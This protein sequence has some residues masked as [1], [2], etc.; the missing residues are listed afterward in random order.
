MKRCVTAAAS[1]LFLLSIL[2]PGIGH[3]VPA[4][5]NYQGLL[6]DDAGPVTDSITMVFRLFDIQTGATPLW[7]ETQVVTV[8]DGIYNV[9]LGD[10]TPNGYYD[11]LESA[12]LASDDLWLE[13][14]IDGEADPMT[15]RQ[16]ITSVGYAIR[17]GTV[18]DGAITAVKLASDAVTT[19]KLVNGAVTADKVT[20][21]AGSGLDADRVDGHSAEYFGTAVELAQARA[22]IATLR[23]EMD[24]LLTL[25]AGVARTGDNIYITGVNLHLRSGGGSTDSAVNGLGNLIIGYD[26]AR[27]S[28]SDKSGSHNLVIGP[29]HNYTSYGGLVAGNNNTVSSASATVSGGA[30]NT[31]DGWACSISGGNLNTASGNYSSVTGGEHNVADGYANSASGGYYNQA[32]GVHSS[33]GGGERNLASGGCSSVGGGENNTASQDH[34]SVSGGG[35]NTASGFLSSI[36]GGQHNTASGNYSTIAGGGGDASTDGNDAFANH[37]VVLGGRGNLAGDGI[38][39]STGDAATVSGGYYNTASGDGSSITGGRYNT[40]SDEQ[41]SVTGG[42]ANTADGLCA[43]VSGG[44]GN[45]A[46]GTDA[47]V[48]GGYDRSAS[49]SWDW[50]AGSLWENN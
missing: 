27:G 7:E 5:I 12:I 3:A 25:L 45:E 28:G 39:H 16:P 37:S 43:T 34:A 8:E 24:A 11:T 36:A 32:N 10:G 1:I 19:E 31:A 4:R 29:K 23:K 26:E 49:G 2:M 41:S 13:V 21:G 46:T 17:A 40:A 20:G 22:E 18:S 48:S 15:P 44:S 38:N 50:A 14:Q 35:N 6:E 30:N 42:A 47:T 33:V 9:I